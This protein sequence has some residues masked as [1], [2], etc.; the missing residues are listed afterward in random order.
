MLVMSKEQM[1]LLAEDHLARRILVFLKK[2]LPE[3]CNKPDVVLLESIRSYIETA[4][5]YGIR[6]ERSMAKWSYLLLL[7][8][9][10]LLDIR[11][12][13]DYLKQPTP[14]QN[15]KPDRLMKSIAVAGKLT[16]I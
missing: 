3:R 9:G 4:S 2:Q 8:D 16:A 5:E 10:K 15:E 13:K 7:T 14:S 1:S 11:G 6:T 12:V